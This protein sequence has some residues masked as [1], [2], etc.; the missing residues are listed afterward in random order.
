[1]QKLLYAHLREICTLTKEV[2]Y[3]LIVIAA[4]QDPVR[5]NFEGTK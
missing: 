1:M 5:K 3:T 4:F 2:L